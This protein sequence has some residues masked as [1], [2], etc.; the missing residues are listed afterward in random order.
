[1]TARRLAFGNRMWD[2]VP[3]SDPQGAPVIDLES[4]R[5]FLAE[6]VD[7]ARVWLLAEPLEQ[8]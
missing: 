4:L 6:L 7:S 3:T 2:A 8:P 5:Q 1:M